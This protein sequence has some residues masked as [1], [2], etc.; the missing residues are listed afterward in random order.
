[1]VNKPHERFS[2]FEDSYIILNTQ[3]AGYS[4]AVEYEAVPDM[5]SIHDFCRSY[6]ERTLGSD[7]LVKHFLPAYVSG[8]IEYK[9]D[10]SNIGAPSNGELQEMIK[11]FITGFSVGKTIQY[12]DII[13]YI[14][15]KTDPSDQYGGYVK[16][17]T[18]KATIHNTD[19]SLTVISG[20]GEL[21]IPTLDPF[22]KDTTRPLSP[23]IVHWIG[24]EIT[25]IRL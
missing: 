6:N 10:P 19:G 15:R 20:N 3:Y 16:P 22:P 8:T 11:D 12:S 7:I 18:L 1:M 4:V 9:V 24:D 13:Q 23:Q 21:Q 14:V 25:L 5:E 17:F 2:V